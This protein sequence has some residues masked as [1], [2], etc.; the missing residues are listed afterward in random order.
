MCPQ[1]SLLMF[2]HLPPRC[3]IFPLHIKPSSFDVMSLFALIAALLLEQ[4]HPL[5]SRK[6]LYG[7]LSAYANLFAHHFN[8]GERRHGK[9][10]WML[11]CC[12]CCSVMALSQQHTVFIGIVLGVQ[13]AS[14]LPPWVSPVQPLLHR[15]PSCAA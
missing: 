5:S 9:I 2:C 3:A 1:T 11:R 13:R 10:A 8:A 12:H 7:W 14:A 4:L 15:Y 6:Y